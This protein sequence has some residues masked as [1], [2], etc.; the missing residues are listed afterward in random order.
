[1]GRKFAVKNQLPPR[2]NL[3]HLKKQA[4]ALHREGKASTLTEAQRL[5]AD[6]YGFRNWPALRRHVLA[7]QNSAEPEKVIRLLQEAVAQ[8]KTVQV[9]EILDAYPE[10][11]DERY[12]PAMRTPLHCAVI[13]NRKDLVR[14]LLERDAD[15]NIRCE[16]DCATPAHF[17]AEKANLD[18]LRLLLDHGA[19]P[20]GAGDYHE[21]E[22]IGWACCFGTGN[23]EVVDLLLQK[24]AAHNIFSA[25][26]LG[27]LEQIH[28]IV[29]KDRTQLERRMDLAN[30]R[31]RPLHLAV[32]KNRPDS[33]DALLQLGADCESLDEAGL[34]ALDAA[35]LRD[36]GAMSERLLSHGAKVR[37][38]AAVALERKDDITRLLRQDP[39]CLKPGNRWGTLIVRAAEKS[40]GRVVQLLLQIG[41]DPN[42]RDDPKTAVDSTSGYTPLHAAAFHGNSSAVEVLLSNGANVQAR[43]E[44]YAGTPAGWA[45][46]AG[47]DEICNRILQGAIDPFEA[48]EMGL[49]DRLPQILTRDPQALHRRF[50]HYLG[51]PSTPVPSLHPGVNRE[52]WRTPLQFAEAIG[53]EQ[54]VRILRSWGTN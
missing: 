34:T 22:V 48:I 10:I 23:R 17:A 41:A 38:P 40:H 11:I 47:H 31:R 51:H 5:L 46:F 7:K 50:E 4:K 20:I 14:L 37:L 19:D 18:I 42:V 32:V 9:A 28:Q 6:S 30:Q 2:P 13:G 3:E 1:M 53:N 52:G 39:D 15:P 29:A 43:D 21:L 33:L 8:G 27:A 45:A 54:A 36:Y 16:G 49:A 25:V 12:G 44:R 24:G 26:S 35:A